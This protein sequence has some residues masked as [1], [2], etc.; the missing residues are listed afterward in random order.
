MD[1]AG[2]MQNEPA[3]KTA[4]ELTEALAFDVMP[5]MMPLVTDALARIVVMSRTYARI[6]ETRCN[7][8]LLQ[9][10]E[11]QE[12]TLETDICSL[13]DILPPVVTGKLTV[14]F[15]GDPRGY[16]VKLH[17]PNAP[18]LG[19]TWGLDGDYGVA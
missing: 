5:A 10:E 12:S 1:I 6:Q 8:E 11:L 14:R 3:N 7:R 2:S 9:W 18:R 4:R 15:G 19:N 13:V 17:V 16:C